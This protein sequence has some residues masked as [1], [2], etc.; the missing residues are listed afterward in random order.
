[1][2]IIAQYSYGTKAINLDH[3]S[4]IETETAKD[5]P[6]TW[7]YFKDAKGR[8]FESIGV[9]MGPTD[10]RTLVAVMLNH[11]EPTFRLDQSQLIE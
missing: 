8:R 5:R 6:E 9:R 4:V 1:M 2:W 10:G 11:R 7:L 3:V